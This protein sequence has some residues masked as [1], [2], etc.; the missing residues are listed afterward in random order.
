MRKGTQKNYEVLLTIFSNF[1]YLVLKVFNFDL[2]LYQSKLK[3][4]NDIYKN[5]FQIF[6]IFKKKK[7]EKKILHSLN[8]FDHGQSKITFTAISICRERWLTIIFATVKFTTT[9]T[10]IVTITL[11]LATWVR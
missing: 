6:Y 1:T 8:R 5:F 10:V 7:K 9:F 4:I 3:A 2:K 11:A